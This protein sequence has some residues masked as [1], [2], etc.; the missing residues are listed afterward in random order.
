[1]SAFSDMT[2]QFFELYGRQAYA[3]ALALVQ[4]SLPAFPEHRTELITWEICMQSC[5]GC[6]AEAIQALTDA[7]Q[8]STYWWSPEALHYDADLA[9]L[10]GNPEYERLVGVCKD[11]Q[12]KARRNSRGRR[13][14]FAPSPLGAKKRPLLIAFHGWGANAE[15]E[16]PHWQGLA[17]RGW[18]VAV[19]RSSQP[20]A[21]GMYVWDDLERTVSDAKAHYEALGRDFPIDTRRV[22]LAGFS[23]GGGRALWLALTRAIPAQGLIGVGPY[24]D[25]FDTLV[26]TLSPPR[27]SKPHVYLVT[28]EHEDDEGMFAQ[29]E[30]LCKERQLP[31]HQEIVPGIGHEYPPDFDPI[32]QRALAFIFEPKKD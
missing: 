30:G 8:T 20:M 5:L 1:M 21:D 19:P 17:E 9:P 26:P 15:L 7:L 23:Q 28:G 12:R 31:F 6:S 32:L 3:E 10:Q 11:R 13:R 4:G 24:L 25:E 18:L 2:G 27:A 14:V 16:A 22:V 29:F